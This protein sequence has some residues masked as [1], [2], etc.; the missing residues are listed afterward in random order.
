MFLSLSLSP[1]RTLSLSLSRARARCFSP[2][3]PLSVPAEGTDIFHVRSGAGMRPTTGPTATARE[4]VCG[5]DFD[6]VFFSVCA[7][8]G[9]RMFVRVCGEFVSKSVSM[10][11]DNSHVRSGVGARPTAPTR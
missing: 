1:Y 5:S 9:V 11:T 10:C 2:S 7:K 8:V 3:L 6:G 4:N